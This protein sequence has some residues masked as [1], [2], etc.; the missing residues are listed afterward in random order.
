[1]QNYNNDKYRWKPKIITGVPG[2]GEIPGISEIKPIEKIQPVR[3][4]TTWSE[5]HDAYDYAKQSP[6]EQHF[7]A[8]YNDPEELNSYLDALVNRKAVSKEFGETWGTIS[9]IS[10][11]VAVIS[12]IA[13][14]ALGALSFFT[15]GA[16]AAPA[17]AAAKTGISAILGTA[18]GV[19]T[20]VGVGASIP[21][22]PAAA[23]VTYDYT[24]KPIVHGKPE[25]A[26]LNTMMNL[27]ETMDYA[28]NPVKG[29]VMEGPQGFL[30]ATGLTNEG[31]TNYDYDTGFVVTDMLLEFVSDP[32]NYIELPMG[33]LKGKYITKAATNAA[34][35][36]IKNVDT[37]VET[38]CKIVVD[39]DIQ[40][41][42]F[43]KLIKTLKGIGTEVTETQARG[44]LLKDN[45]L[46]KV[47]NVLQTDLFSKRKLTKEELN[48]LTN[49]MQHKVYNA[50]VNYIKE[51]APKATD[52]DVE[53]ILAKAG[54][55]IVKD[56]TLG[57]NVL[58][59]IQ[60]DDLSTSA[61]RALHNVKETTD[62]VQKFMTRNALASPIVGLGL[63]ITKYLDNKLLKWATN[64][65][66]KRLENL[67][68]FDKT[69]GLTNLAEYEAF[70]NTLL[71]TFKYHLTKVNETDA[72]TETT[73]NSFYALM[74]SQYGR[75]EYLI[76]TA[77][78]DH[79]GKPIE[80]AAAIDALIQ[81]T[82]GVDFNAY[83]QFLEKI[84]ITEGGIYT[85]YVQHAQ[86]VQKTLLRT[87][88]RA[89]AD[90]TLIVVEAN[91]YAKQSID[92][93]VTRSKEL[94]EKLG[95]ASIAD[96]QAHPEK[97]IEVI[98]EFKQS[99]M[100]LNAMFMNDPDYW[101]LITSLTEGGELNNIFGN[102][103]KIINSSERYRIF[104]EYEANMLKQ[105]EDKIITEY[106]ALYNALYK[107]EN[108]SAAYSEKVA[109]RLR[110]KAKEVVK[111]QYPEIRKQAFESMRKQLKDAP[112]T[113]KRILSTTNLSIEGYT[114]L[115]KQAGVMDQRIT[116]FKYFLDTVK[117]SAEGYTHL[118]TLYNNI[119]TLMLPKIEGINDKQF[120]KYVLYNLV[121]TSES[122]SDALANYDNTAAKVFYK[123]NS[124]FEDKNFIITDYPEV[125]EQIKL[126][127]KDYL[128]GLQNLG[129]EKVND[130]TVTNFIKR[131]KNCIKNIRDNCDADIIPQQITVL[132]TMTRSMEELIEMSKHAEE[133]S[134]LDNIK[135]MFTNENSIFTK[136]FQRELIDADL[137]LAAKHQA[138]NATLFS[139]LPDSAKPYAQQIIKLGNNITTM[140]EQ[141]TKHKLDIT[142]IQSKIIAQLFRLS[143]E[144]VA[145]SDE[146]VYIQFKY[147]NKTED[148][149]TQ[150]AYITQLQ[151][152][153]KIDNL[154]NEI[155]KDFFKDALDK[156]S[157]VE[158][159]I[160]IT[161]VDKQSV[162]RLIAKP[163]DYFTTEGVTWD[164]MR[165]TAHTTELSF[166]K[167][168]LNIIG[169]YDNLGA[170]A[171]KMTTSFEAM[172]ELYAANSADLPK[173]LQ[174][175]RYVNIAKQFQST[176]NWF[177][178]QYNKLFD[179]KL[180]EKKLSEY[181]DWLSKLNIDKAKYK[182]II[183]RLEQY[184]NG[185]LQYTA[186]E[187]DKIVKEL[188]ETLF[189]PLKE[190]EKEINTY[191]EEYNT[192]L[193]RH[194]MG[195][196]D[197]MSDIE[198][199][200]RR[201]GNITPLRSEYTSADGRYHFVYDHNIKKF[202]S[203]EYA[204][205]KI[206]WNDELKE[207]WIT[208]PNNISVSKYKADFIKKHGERPESLRLA[209]NV[210][211]RLKKDV[212]A[213]SIKDAFEKRYA[214]LQGFATLL[215]DMDDNPKLKK[216]LGDDIFTG[217]TITED[218]S[219]KELLGD[220]YYPAIRW[221]R[222]YDD[223]FVKVT[224]ADELIEHLR[225]DPEYT[226]KRY[227]RKWLEPDET[228]FNKEEYVKRLKETKQDNKSIEQILNEHYEKYVDDAMASARVYYVR[229]M[230]K[231]NK[232]K[233]QALLAR[234]G[235]KYSYE[236]FNDLLDTAFEMF[237]DFDDIEELKKELI[238]RSKSDWDELIKSYKVEHPY[239]T[240]ADID[241]Y[242]AKQSAEDSKKNRII[243]REIR[244]ARNA[245]KEAGD[246][247]PEHWFRTSTEPDHI[248]IRQY[249][250]DTF[251]YNRKLQQMVS[252]AFDEA[253]ARYK[254][255]PLV[256][257]MRSQITKAVREGYYKELRYARSLGAKQHI[258]ENNKT[259]LKQAII[260]N[261][262]QDYVEPMLRAY[263][264]SDIIL[265]WDIAY[266]QGLEEAILKNHEAFFNFYLKNVSEPNLIIKS[267]MFEQAKAQN[268]SAYNNSKLKNTKIDVSEP[269]KKML[270]VN[271]ALTRATDL[272]NLQTMRTLF[273]MSA[274][275]F[276]NELA[277]RLG[278][279]TFMEDDLI[280][281]PNVKNPAYD[282]TSSFIHFLDKIKDSK[283]IKYL[284]HPFEVLD[285][286]G[287]TKTHTR[288]WIMLAPDV[289]LTKQDRQW[290]INGRNI[291][292]KISN[293]NLDYFKVVDK[294]LDAEAPDTKLTTGMQRGIS[295]I[296]EL[297]G[298][299]L[300]TS[301][302]EVIDQ[303]TIKKL[304][305]LDKDTGLPKHMSREV[306]EMFGGKVS[307]TGKYTI[308]LE[309]D[310]R[311]SKK[312][313]NTIMYNESILGSIK[314][315]NML[316]G[317]TYSGNFLRNLTHTMSQGQY[318]VKAKT[319]YVNTF[320][321]SA[322]SVNGGLYKNYSNADILA[323]LQLNTDYKLVALV[324]DKKYGIKVREILPTSIAA[325][326]KAKELN[327]IIVPG[328]I[329]KDMFNTVNHRI[330][331]EGFM[332]IWNRIMYVI[333]F[334]YLLNPGTWLRNIADTNIKTQIELG[335]EAH[336]YKRQA[337]NLIK[338]YDKIN[339]YITKR[340]KD[341]VIKLEAL[342]EWFE[343]NP[344]SILNLES[345][346]EITDSWFNQ[347]VSGGI[348]KQFVSDD[349]WGTMTHYASKIMD[350]AT[351]DVER[352]NRLAIYLA[353]LDK[354]LDVTSALS[355]VAKTHFDYSFKTGVEQ[356]LEAVFPFSTY[357]L[358]NLSYWAEALDKHPW[359]MRMY[360][361]IMKPNW[362][363]Q[364]Y[365]P[366]ELAANQQVRNQILN[367]QLKLGEFND[368]LITLKLNPSL[369]D[370]IKMASN[371]VNAI[372]EKLAAPIAVPLHAALD[373]YTNPLS[374]I[375]VAGP[376]IQRGKQMIKQGN[377]AP[378]I[379]NVM[380][381]PRKTGQE[382][383]NGK[384]SNVQLAKANEYRD[385]QRRVPR[386]RNNFVFDA[387]H[388]IGTKRYRNNMY[389]IIDIAHD[390][391][392][393]YSIDVYNKIRNQ[394]KTDVRKD[395]RYRIKIDA[396]RFR[397]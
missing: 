52:A 319:E 314:N 395:I 297:T 391:K 139:A 158:D 330:G 155:F 71:N 153:A 354:G 192:G 58:T 66:L 218:T 238:T 255:D 75:D 180:A 276:E 160:N 5:L 6:Q 168:L 371:P 228:E 40:D 129:I 385:Q 237:R 194:Y 182:D 90:P 107:A 24:I 375:P 312:L 88:T 157:N 42:S 170:S 15:G 226:Y 345:Y 154:T 247:L 269:V 310:T 257:E 211:V 264:T 116:T 13:A 67:K 161:D 251:G 92:K 82:Y 145:T 341:G 350:A 244:A 17:G 233:L 270:A 299:S 273:E 394:V 33:I 93:W 352:V 41:K 302:G 126:V 344:K 367:G 125:C 140:V 263:D 100:A 152:A 222:K 205:R 353:D 132:G 207:K 374:L 271:A 362:D 225:K 292:R 94:Y 137:M 47:L 357:A 256:Q 370:A 327:A 136:A 393:Q 135:Y 373:Q 112:E 242:I 11:T 14:A 149:Y 104:K 197:I 294:L 96:L 208:D 178:E 364:D 70:K 267:K 64:N 114:T 328:Q 150:L 89:G 56:N 32:M 290:R 320:F 206:V 235:Y 76:K 115:A 308:D 118:K 184:W 303:A 99:D 103:E 86:A 108:K 142:D 315:K 283:T 214:G 262:G 72:L 195:F 323:A 250:D 376:I 348:A 272:N 331:S 10:G 280:L 183:N 390:I 79:A 193:Y 167:D 217:K 164:V 9:T 389:P 289:Q 171:K 281:D 213:L 191:I 332:K 221:F 98:Y 360:V 188:D 95:K 131:T 133:L 81:E 138:K 204:N 249:F 334:G 329:Y 347:S 322:F 38:I 198:D 181:R 340:S 163:Y 110:L 179:S 282:L 265:D 324:Y 313:F 106:E 287:N 296:E 55:K 173:M 378:S 151:K 209:D 279:V 382:T 339:D 148:V 338:E 186:T 301:Q 333:K 212:E 119:D 124:L 266:A 166:N 34:E 134:G 227:G 91:T 254:T 318:Y 234:S 121:N 355:H 165:A 21:A 300:S 240:E 358:R 29:L 128:I 342:A 44:T 63:D 176:L 185:T 261:Y 316:E 68:Y 259:L 293:S 232:K 277:F 286:D 23:K 65:T 216:L 48:A 381:A 202:D 8:N 141:F 19:A 260:E 4:I 231:F 162:R 229:N 306:W 26:L 288:Y 284:S 177:T 61:I 311:F 359:L 295:N 397:K 248:I 388:T 396:N 380:N 363:L 203:E 379:L 335:T 144:F 80:Q 384:W 321:D 274:E 143:Q 337:K 37:S 43:K 307:P 117:Q 51:I 215:L 309:L 83:V 366:E 368:K 46:R 102:L 7:L 285:A 84:N 175:E 243:Q 220:K 224:S 343:A 35:I 87:S 369:Q 12:F 200:F 253:S 59:D 36:L 298:T 356:L 187:P 30:K 372:Y 349:T 245:H 22:I 69:L 278:F 336:S 77:L 346:Q 57:L 25:Q 111:Q 239:A 201:E 97:M 190:F 159:L 109:T 147:F 1:M 196:N 18:A 210:Q 392:M 120:R 291:T 169:A 383:A 174:M 386:Y 73:T 62:T 365:T 219:L 172:R 236:E 258:K 326:E 377:P 189:K 146:A 53:N 105:A 156:V 28:A 78:A 50:V 101:Q 246:V 20:K 113:F 199:E 387:Y 74:K 60:L 39:T 127:Y 361:D 241:K 45:K 223:T 54:K 31:R 130:N 351:G 325:I 2:I 27:G 304:F 317:I 252:A 268:L 49:N 275:D 85:D 16:T 3:K 122:V 230:R 123:L 305:E